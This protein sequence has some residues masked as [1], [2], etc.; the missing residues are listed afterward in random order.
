M[1]EESSL[2]YEQAFGVLRQLHPFAQFR[3]AR[4]RALRALQRRPC[5]TII[6]TS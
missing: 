3:F 1:P 2:G 6:R 4:S 5:I